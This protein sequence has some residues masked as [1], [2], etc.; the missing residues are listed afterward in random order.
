[1]FCFCAL[2]SL[3]IYCGK[4][5]H[6]QENAEEDNGVEDKLAGPAAVTRNLAKLQIT[7]S[8]WRVVITDRYYTSVRL[9]LALWD[10]R[11]YIVGTCQTNRLGFCKAVID[12]RKTRPKDVPRGGYKMAFCI[13]KPEMVALSWMDSKPVHMLA[14][15]CGIGEGT[16]GRRNKRG[17]SRQVTCPQPLLDYHKW[18]GGVDIHDQLRLQRYS[19]QLALRFKKYYKSL[20]LGLVDT[21]LVNAFIVYRIKKT[22]NEEKCTRDKFLSVLQNQLL[23][24][25]D[26]EFEMGTYSQFQED[27]SVEQSPEQSSE[28]VLQESPEFQEVKLRDGT[29]SK[30]R[31]QRACKVCS[32][33]KTG[34]ARSP[35][36]KFFCP[37]CSTGLKRIYLC[38]RIRRQESGNTLTCS[39]I[40][41][42][43]WQNGHAIPSSIQRRI[44]IRSVS[45]RPGKK[46]RRA[47]QLSEDM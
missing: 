13:E 39:Q 21:A 12:N 1:M 2:P 16:V 17:I 23:S 27:D 38:D 31:R 6:L 15:G 11:F 25:T 40:W 10:M 47:R 45:T 20:F 44:Q 42:S 7:D 5:Q 33:L 8:S 41:H 34:T 26:E 18:M 36:S 19:L 4:K 29:T 14:T 37:K 22:Q 28:H 9:A 43:E 35:N 3:E 24:I 30:K 46:K 32:L